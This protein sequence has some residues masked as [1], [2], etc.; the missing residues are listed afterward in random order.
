MAETR[1]ITL[2]ITGMTCANC[3]SAVER[4]LKKVNG[5][6][7]ASVN[8]SSER[9]T[10][11]VDLLTASLDDLISRV[12]RAGYGIAEGEASLAILRMSDDNDA[13]RI[14][15]ALTAME[16]VR[17][18]QV[19]YTTERASIRYIPTMI[20]QAEIRRAIS[21]AG[22]EVLESGGEAEDAEAAA[23]EREIDQQK[24]HLVVGLIFTIPLFLIAMAG[25]LGFLSMEISHSSWIKWV[26]LALATPVQFYVGAQYYVGAYKS[27]RNGA[28]NMD[29]LVALGSSAAFFIPCRLRLVSFTGMFI[30]KPRQSSLP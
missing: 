10:V 24:R 19:S 9:A 26:M 27:L 29:V 4:N 14:E 1:L 7:S 22:F 17:D 20:S 21:A 23:R 11:E 28:A 2:P 12:Q 5:V 13:R 3:S 30:L 18:V 6:Q 15:K 8:L 16:G 25:D